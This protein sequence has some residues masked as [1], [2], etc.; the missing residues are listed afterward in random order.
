MKPTTLHI[1]S[2]REHAV[3]ALQQYGFEAIISSR[4][5]DIFSNN[6]GKNGLVICQLDEPD[7]QLLA[8]AVLADP[9][10]EFQIDVAESKVTAGKIDFNRSFPI[11]EATRNRLINGLD[12][13]A[14]SLQNS[15]QIADFE[16]T[17]PNWL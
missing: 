5:G 16:Q 2:S 6:S 15:N 14:L 9:S 1:G 8:D 13:I 17:R 3:W 7:I 12:D 11:P 10:L 4:F